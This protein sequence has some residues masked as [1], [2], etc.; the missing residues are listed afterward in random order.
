MVFPSC[1]Y[2][3]NYSVHNVN[4][5]HSSSIRHNKLVIRHNQVR[6]N[7]VCATFDLPDA[8]RCFVPAFDG[9]LSFNI[10]QFRAVR[11]HAVFIKYKAS[12]GSA[13][14]KIHTNTE[15]SFY[16]EKIYLT[17]FEDKYRK[18]K[19]VITVLCENQTALQRVSV[20]Q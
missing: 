18:V 3:Q 15:K 13:Q 4:T 19:E 7:Q 14:S 2:I 16:I 5:S 1:S 10:Y 9:R 6:H 12:N 20:P 11:R 8:P 17:C